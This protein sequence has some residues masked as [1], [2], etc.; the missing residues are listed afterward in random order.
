MKQKLMC[1]LLAACLI[2]SS[3]SVNAAETESLDVV[4]L[5]ETSAEEPSEA[6]RAGN[7]VRIV[8]TG[9]HGDLHSS[10]VFPGGKEDP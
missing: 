1:F 4:Q 10:G 6:K 5:S 2:G 9:A 7:G 3:L 8:R